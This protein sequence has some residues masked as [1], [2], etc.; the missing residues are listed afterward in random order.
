[1]LGA[2]FYCEKYPSLVF[3]PTGERM[4]SN[5]GGRAGRKEEASTCIL[6]HVLVFGV[7]L[8]LICLFFLSQR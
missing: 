8:L 1:M 7:F 6:Q 2:A 3:P 5:I 4:I